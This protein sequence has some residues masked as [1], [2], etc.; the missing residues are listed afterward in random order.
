MDPVNRRHVWE[1]IEN[2]KKGRAII[3]TTHSMEEA[4]ILG[5]DIAIMALGKL[6]FFSLFIFYFFLFLNFQ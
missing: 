1:F 4:D 2:F 3:L 6:R 5:D